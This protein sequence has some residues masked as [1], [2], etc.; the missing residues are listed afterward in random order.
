MLW[1]NYVLLCCPQLQ[2]QRQLPVVSAGAVTPEVAPQAL[3][4]PTT[5]KT[6]S[7]AQSPEKGSEK[8]GLEPMSTQSSQPILQKR[9][10]GLLQYPAVGF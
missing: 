4:M 2:P 9:L 6:I 3:W 7:V 1:L 10:F 5:S 8:K